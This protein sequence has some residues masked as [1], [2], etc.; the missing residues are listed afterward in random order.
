MKTADLRRRIN[1]R[2][3]G[4]DP[5]RMKTVHIANGLYLQVLGKQYPT[6]TINRLAVLVSKKKSTQSRRPHTTDS[7]LEDLPNV[8]TI[9]QVTFNWFRQHVRELLNA[10]SAVFDHHVSAGC[11]YSAA[12]ARLV[13]NDRHNDGWSGNFVGFFLAHDYGDGPSIVLEKVREALCDETDPL[14]IMALPF[15]DEPEAADS[16][17]EAYNGEGETH[18][19]N[20]LSDLPEEMISLRHA[21]D[22]FAQYYPAYLSKER[23]TRL[24][25]ILSSIVL[26]RHIV[27]LARM[28]L[29]INRMPFLVDT[30]QKTSTRMRLAS[31]LTY[32]RCVV[33]LTELYVDLV[34]EHIVNMAKD[35]NS[36]QTPTPRMVRDACDELIKE[37]E[38]DLFKKVA[39]AIDS[40]IP[41]DE[42]LG[43]VARHVA[44]QMLDQK[45][46]FARG[47]LRDVGIR[48]GVLMPRGNA[49]QTKHFSLQPDTLEALVLA[50]VGPNNLPLTMGE[51]AEVL[52]ER[53]GIL[54]GGR[55][56]DME[57]LA[58]VAIREVN[59]DDLDLNYAAFTR[60]MVSLGLARQHSDGL[61]L[62]RPVWK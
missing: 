7:L 27:T 17:Y 51:F 37:L 2:W 36:T 23:F 8:Q 41:D 50:C 56:E 49:Q 24:L 18:F 32:V 60:M 38:E 10:D 52:W 9:D 11:A 54:V 62:V 42:M 4:Y 45:E 6:E 13:T 1:A 26:L 14:S 55:Q 43:V 46:E 39:P 33:N 53:F 15:L 34:K 31:Q 21:M 57:T 16:F 48:C 59:Q 44:T 61:V 22:T 28:R 29:G 19:E 5:D 58:G 40:D 30:L 25:V 12:N 35:R 20:L 3:I 47:F